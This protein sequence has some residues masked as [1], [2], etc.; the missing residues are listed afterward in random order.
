MFKI[1]CIVFETRKRNPNGAT[2]NLACLDMR[3]FLETARF[4]NLR[5]VTG[6]R[7]YF[8][9]HAYLFEILACI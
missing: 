8:L 5:E 3:G 2:L 9:T 6:A 1:K 4:Y 7:F